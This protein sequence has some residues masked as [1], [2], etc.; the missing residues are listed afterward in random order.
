MPIGKSIAGGGKFSVG[1]YRRPAWKIQPGY[2]QTQS[3]ARKMVQHERNARSRR[4]NLFRQTHKNGNILEQKSGGGGAAAAAAPSFAHS[5]RRR[6]INNNNNNNSNAVS[7]VNTLYQKNSKRNSRLQ[8]QG[9][10]RFHAYLTPAQIAQQSRRF[11]PRIHNATNAT[12]SV[13][14]FGAKDLPSM[15]TWDNFI[16]ESQAPAAQK[17]QQAQRRVGKRRALSTS[18]FGTSVPLSAFVSGGSAPTM[19]ARRRKAPGE[20]SVTNFEVLKQTYHQQS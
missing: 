6:V 10:S 12:S 4:E 9:P 20:P 13:I 19:L 15:G 1:F 2:D 3:R 11:G 5:R 18:R 16:P 14:G 8:R 17:Q 7:S